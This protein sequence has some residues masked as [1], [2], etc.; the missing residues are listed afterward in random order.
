[1]DRELLKI[2]GMA[3]LADTLIVID[4]YMSIKNK[5]VKKVLK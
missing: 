4:I 3:A 2:F 1:M 5:L